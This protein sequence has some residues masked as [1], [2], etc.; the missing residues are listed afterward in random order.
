MLHDTKKDVFKETLATDVDPGIR[1]AS[2]QSKIPRTVAVSSIAKHHFRSE[3]QDAVKDSVLKLFPDAL[4]D[5]AVKSIGAKKEPGIT[6]VSTSMTWRGRMAP[7]TDAAIGQALA[8][9]EIAHSHLSTTFSSSLSNPGDRLSALQKDLAASYDPLLTS[10]QDT[11]DAVR[12]AITEQT[13]EGASEADS[14]IQDL[15]VQDLAA[16]YAL[17]SCRIGRNRALISSFHNKSA[18]DSTATPQKHDSLDDGLHFY[19]QPPSQHPSRKAASQVGA[20]G[21]MKSP[22]SESPHHALSRL[23]TRVALYDSIV[24]SIQQLAALPGAAR[25]VEFTSELAGAASYFAALRCINIAYSYRVVAGASSNSNLAED[26]RTKEKAALALFAKAWSYVSAEGVSLPTS[27]ESF[28]TLSIDHEQLAALR[29]RIRDLLRTQRGLVAL[30]CDIPPLRACK[31]H[32]FLNLPKPRGKDISTSKDITAAKSKPLISLLDDPG[33][34][35]P[36]DP[37]LVD[38]RNIVPWPPNEENLKVEAVPVKPIFLDIAYNYIKY[39]HEK[40]RDSKSAKEGRSETKE[41]KEEPKKK[42]WFGFGRS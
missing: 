14:R 25:D 16:N 12:S 35:L 39:P 36:T 5:D 17:V 11:A 10:A 9:R 41:V 24:Q 2:Y 4:T 6:H 1:Y 40:E 31:N 22:K 30:Q 37:P 29:S 26:P 15:R 38:L 19:A 34:T 28:P 42:G 21:V 20:K 27:E 8:A 32:P 13:R 23:A 3:P 33:A 7:I 18:Q